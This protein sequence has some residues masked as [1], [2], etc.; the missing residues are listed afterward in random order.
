MSEV[1]LIRLLEAED[2][3][4]KKRSNSRTFPEIPKDL[5]SAIKDQDTE[6]PAG[7]K[8]RRQEPQ[9]I[10][11]LQLNPKN[12]EN[13]Y[14]IKKNRNHLVHYLPNLSKQL[15]LSSPDVAVCLISVAHS[16]SLCCWP[17]TSWEELFLGWCLE[18]N[19]LLCFLLISSV[20]RFS[21]RSFLVS[22]LSLELY[23]I[24]CHSSVLLEKDD[25]L[26]LSFNFWCLDD[27]IFS[28]VF[29]C[30]NNGMTLCLLFI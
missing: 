19:L 28:S 9:Y 5:S 16:C 23:K 27:L 4:W 26:V 12:K 1:F 24:F 11:V 20:C 8:K 18:G 2:R 17:Q 3:L 25:Y 6:A 21:D 10:L 14:I 15:P 13:P 7:I 29:C 30:L 22:Q